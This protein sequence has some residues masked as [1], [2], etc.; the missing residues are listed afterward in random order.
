[1]STSCDDTA[2]DYHRVCNKLNEKKKKYWNEEEVDN[3]I[4]G[5]QHFTDKCISPDKRDEGHKMQIRN[6]RRARATMS[7]IWWFVTSSHSSQMVLRPKSLHKTRKSFFVFLLSG[8]LIVF[9]FD[10]LRVVPDGKGDVLA[11]KVRTWTWNAHHNIEIVRHRSP[12]LRFLCTSD[13]QTPK[14]PGLR[15]NRWCER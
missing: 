13:W 11:C 5:R 6:L 15:Q 3:C 4:D 1:M 7:K 12:M 9:F 14:A 8:T 2:D 10:A